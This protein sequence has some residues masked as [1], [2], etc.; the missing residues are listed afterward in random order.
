MKTIQSKLARPYPYL[1]F[2]S[3]PVLSPPLLGGLVVPGLPGFVGVVGLVVPGFVGLVGFVGLPG[4]AGVVSP[5]F[6]VAIGAGVAFGCDPDG[7][8]GL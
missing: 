2:T 8:C 6:P 1:K 3:T 4:S 5:S 7:I